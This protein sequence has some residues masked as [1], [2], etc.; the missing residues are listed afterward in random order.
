MVSIRR[1]DE[2]DR[3]AILMAGIMSDQQTI[4][5]RDIEC[6]R[7]GN[8]LRSFSA[9]AWM[10][11]IL[12]L[13]F[14]AYAATLG[15]KFAWDDQGQIVENRFVQSWH[16]ASQLFVQQ[17]WAQFGATNRANYYRPIFMLWLLINHTFWGLHPT[18]WHLTSVFV[19]LA[20]VYFAF[21]VTR[22]LSG[23]TTTAL[24]TALLFGVHPIHIE[25]VAWIAGVTDPLMTAFLLPAFLFYLDFRE[26]RRPALSLA[27]LMLLYSL[28]LLEKETAVIFPALLVA[29][30]ALFHRRGES[31]ES[32]RKRTLL[33]L[34]CCAAITG[35]YL[36]I[37]SRVLLGLGHILVPIPWSSIFLTWPLVVW[38]YARHLAFPFGLSGFYPDTYLLAPD[39]AH[40]WMPLVSVLASLALVVWLWIRTRSPMVRFAICLMVLPLIPVLNLRLLPPGQIVHDRYLY[41][42]SLGYCMLIAMLLRRIG[43]SS[44][45]WL[46]S[47]ALR[48]G[49]V[50]CIGLSLAVSTALQSLQWGSSLVLYYHGILVSP[51]DSLLRCNLGNELFKLGLL[52]DAIAQYKT[53]LRYDPRYELARYQLGLAYY[54]QKKY[55]EA[56]REFG[57]AVKIMGDDTDSL[58]YEGLSAYRLGDLSTAESTLRNAIQLSPEHP[59]YHYWLGMA[60]DEKGSPVEAAAEFNKELAIHPGDRTA[61]ER[62]AEL[63][64]KPASRP[65]IR[66]P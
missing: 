63:R 39:R 31:G 23:D 29:W 21:L 26:R 4:P 48:I 9:P 59:F 40:F 5:S 7:S 35:V 45:N 11:L 65:S 16:Y 18:G 57:L 37:R 3:L 51:A 24:L 52:D 13:T 64:T 36:A 54:G 28:A 62:L 58:F 10:T 8:L 49:A 20:V 61:Q 38:F 42:P 32:A 6:D 15:F 34:M 47:P 66:V 56:E 43:E 60:L 19:H 53:A 44:W 12:L 46:R 17:V 22:R 55:E 2:A 1:H 30:E 27:L 50:A 25:S 33:A 41:L 14:A